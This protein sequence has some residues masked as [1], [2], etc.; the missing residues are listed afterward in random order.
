MDVHSL[1]VWLINLDRAKER[2]LQ[3]EERLGTLGLEYKRFQAIDG[4]KDWDRLRPSVD[5]SAFRRNVGRDVMPGEIGASHSHLEVWRQLA[6]SDFEI[7]LVLEDDVVFHEDFI[8]AVDAALSV[9]DAWDFLKLNKIRAKQPV[10]QARIDRWQLNAYLGPATG[11]GA[12][13]IRRDLAERLIVACLPIRRPID[14]ELDRLHVHR[15]RHLGLEPFPSHVDDGNVS[16]IT[17][18]NYAQVERFSWYRRLPRY[19]DGIFT[20][21][22]KAVWLIRQGQFR[23]GLRGRNLP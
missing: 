22:G 15:F 1:P 19:L 14:R 23:S 20:L 2:R 10:C 16:T 11:L 21:I 5:I 6:A 17:G 7:G 12:Y 9:K 13:L 3:M 4:R 18:V 8:E